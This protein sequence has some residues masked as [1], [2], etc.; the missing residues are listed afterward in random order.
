MTSTGLS[1]SARREHRSSTPARVASAALPLLL[2]LGCA[3]QSSIQSEM[4]DLRRQVDQVRQQQGRE[5]S[6]RRALEDRV[7]LL[8]DKLE[9]V[10]I[11]R[12][13]APDVTPKLPVVK[14]L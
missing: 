9:T 1:N 13:R 7:A 14:K 5:Q 12:D 3:G 11:A 6:E 8:E 4:I 10:E 2:L